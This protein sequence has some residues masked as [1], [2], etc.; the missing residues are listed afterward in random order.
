M[1]KSAPLFAHTLFDGPLFIAAPMISPWRLAPALVLLVLLPLGVARAGPP[2]VTDDPDPVEDGH[3]EI[4][5]AAAGVRTASATTGV[6]PQFDINYGAAPGV[7]LHV[8]PQMA[9][10]RPADGTRAYGVGDTELGVKVRF[11]DANGPRGEW[12]LSVYPFYEAPTGS[13][14]RGLGAGASS[15]YLPLWLQWSGGGW[16]TFGGGGYWIDSGT[17]RRNAWAAGWTVLYQFTP[18]LQLGGEVFGKTADT[19]GARRSAGFNVGGTYALGENSA[20]LFSAGR[21][22]VNAADSNA[23][24]WYLGWRLTR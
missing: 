16:T 20:L 2:F 19:V 14:R 15:V 17:G 10:S 4:N 8:M 1:Y 22:I 9:Y 21:G 6:V 5:S 18:D 24:A 3:W 12:M 13:A 23:A 7:Q 11:V